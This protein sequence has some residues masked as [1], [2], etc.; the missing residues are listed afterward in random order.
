MRTE[1]RIQLT[2]LFDTKVD[3]EASAAQVKSLVASSK[4]NG[5]TAKSIVLTQDEYLVQ[6]PVNE[7]L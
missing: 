3:M 2:I 1:Y 4:A 6:E 5:F 7:T